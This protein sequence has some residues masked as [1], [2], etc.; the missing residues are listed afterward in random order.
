MTDAFFVL[1]GR[2]QMIL[3]DHPFEE[4]AWISIAI[5]NENV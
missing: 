2:E 4:L 5:S 3:I 1:A